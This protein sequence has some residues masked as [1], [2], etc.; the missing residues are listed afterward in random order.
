MQKLKPAHPREIGRLREHRR[1]RERE[2]ERQPREREVGHVV[3]H[4]LG[5]HPHDRQ[6]QRHRQARSATQH[7][8]RHP[9]HRNHGREHEQR[10]YVPK[11]R[12]LR[13]NRKRDRDPIQIGGVAEHAEPEAESRG[14][15][16]RARLI[17]AASDRHC[18]RDQ[19][20]ER[21]NQQRIRRKR[22]R[23]QQCR[24]RERRVLPRSR[25]V[26][27]TNDHRRISFSS[28]ADL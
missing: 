4:H 21:R 25:K 23:E 3:Q 9:R 2:T 27:S 7:E 1:A 18:E 14:F 11:N 26:S 5:G 28:S 16:Q 8:Q 22:D 6:Q 12:E 17:R 15:A 13:V 24:A 19:T 20:E 10:R